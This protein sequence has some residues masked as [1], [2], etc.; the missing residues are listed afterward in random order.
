MN[1]AT[2]K[3]SAQKKRSHK[4]ESIAR[5]RRSK[6]PASSN[7]LPVDHSQLNMGNATWGLIAYFLDDDVYRDKVF[8]CKGCGSEEVWTAEQ[9]KWWYEE[10]HAFVE[11]R[12]VL[13]RACRIKERQRKAEARRISEEGMAKKRAQQ[14]QNND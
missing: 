13:C 2:K 5:K 8:I 10:I 6:M 3:M 12:A 4:Q 7:T 14:A 1:D 9:Q 11:T